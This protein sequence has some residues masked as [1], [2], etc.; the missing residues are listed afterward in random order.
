MLRVEAE[1]SMQDGPGWCRLRIFG[2]EDRSGP[3]ELMFRR[4]G[5]S[6]I[7]LGPRDWQ[8]S[9]SWLEL[10]AERDGEALL[11][12]LGPPHTL[13]LAK[14]S[15]VELRVRIAGQAAQ[16]TRLPWPRIVL[17]ADNDASGAGDAPPAR[18]GAAVQ[19]APVA[20]PEPAAPALEPLRAFEPLRADAPAVA[21]KAGR[22][23]LTPWAGLG[24]LGV[25]LLVVLL[26]LFVASRPELE[27]AP[28]PARVFSEEAVRAF[29]A[30]NP[31]GPSATA[32]ASL[33]EAA[34]HPD[35]ALLLYRHAARRGEPKAALAIGRMY[36]PDGFDAARSPFAV[37]D[38]DQA[39]RFYEQA[40]E[41][42]DA[43]AQLRLGRLLLSG[44]T[45]GEADAERGALWLQRAAGQGNA[46]ARAAL[47]R[48]GN[49]Q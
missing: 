40:A 7:Y 14:A 33:Y 13:R 15:T 1:Q 47:A 29:L 45:S 35:L 18:P 34:R 20:R 8:E 9:E 19:S 46:E 41:K 22:A 5:A 42:G 32:E 25:L 10:P 12:R 30:A 4:P 28:A 26:S 21:A 6:Q 44:R 37:P 39:A 17:P 48:L 3:V 49:A 16:R 38:G 2:L 24:I 36:D 27:P 23:R 43:E 11:L 31:D